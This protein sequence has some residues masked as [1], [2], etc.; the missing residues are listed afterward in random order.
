MLFRR[1]N[2]WLGNRSPWEYAA[3]TATG[4]AIGAAVR[5]SEGTLSRPAR[6]RLRLEA[7]YARSD[8]FEWRRLLMDDRAAY[9]AGERP[10]ETTRPG[11]NVEPTR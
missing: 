1:M 3:V 5:V 4:M 10:P 11:G 6:W 2:S 8:L 9:L 7:A